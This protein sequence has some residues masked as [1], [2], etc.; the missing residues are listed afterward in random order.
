MA[1]PSLFDGS[2]S[3]GKGYQT[4]GLL[5]SWLPTWIVLKEVPPTL[6][7]P[8]GISWLASK[9]GQPVNK[10]VRDG[11]VVKV[12]VGKD[13]S[14]APLSN[15]SVMLDDD[16]KVVV[17]VEYPEPRSYKKKVDMI[18][19]ERGKGVVSQPKIIVPVTC[20]SCNAL[21]PLL[22]RE[23][24]PKPGS[25]EQVGGGTGN[26]PK[27]SLQTEGTPV[28]QDI[29]VVCPNPVK[30]TEDGALLSEYEVDEEMVAKSDPSLET[31]ANI[32]S[33]IVRPTL[34]S[35]KQSNDVIVCEGE[36]GKTSLHKLGFADFLIH[37]KLSPKGVVHLTKTRRR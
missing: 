32:P 7:T 11:L 31:V 25:L 13:V 8:K 36:G 17:S 14:R 6:I 15:I 22:S 5:A 33:T 20:S 21:E 10:F 29:N 23:R 37:S 35:P 34:P 9:I 1:H 27:V 3:L 16:E 28:Q 4:A 19:L 12:F 26:G 18:W 2:P 30:V 24:A